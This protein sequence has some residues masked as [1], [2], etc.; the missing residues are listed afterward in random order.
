MNSS[1]IEEKVQ[2]PSKKSFG[3]S[4]KLM[5]GFFIIGCIFVLS[6][7]IS[8][9][10]I[11]NT[12]TFSEQVIKTELPIYDN[13]VDLN[14]EVFKFNALIQT[15]IIPN[16]ANLKK[17]ISSNW[18]TIQS[19]EAIIDRL[20]QNKSNSDVQ[21][22]WLNVK[23]LIS[24]LRQEQENIFNTND[25]S[26]QQI[27]AAVRQEG[28]GIEQITAGMNKTNQVTSSFLVS[29]KQTTAAITDLDSLVKNLKS[30]VETYKIKD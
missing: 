16:D 13:I 18:Y 2:L 21:T 28:A 26:A 11:S 29:V 23:S 20:I 3:L 19:I 1:Y 17:R 25:K 12:E 4:Q 27:E 8:L 30:S 15:W 14:S 5:L 9:V 6:I 10:M 24:Q 22:K 7:N